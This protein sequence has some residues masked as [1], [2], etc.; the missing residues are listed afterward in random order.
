MVNRFSGQ[1]RGAL[2]HWF[3]TRRRTQVSDGRGCVERVPRRSRFAPFTVVDFGAIHHHIARSGD[4]ET[5]LLAVDAE[6]SDDNVIADMERFVRA[7]GQTG[8]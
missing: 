2:V 4:A 7:A 5:D 1:S 8:Q 6:D 3:K